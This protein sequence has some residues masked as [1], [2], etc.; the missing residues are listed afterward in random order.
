MTGTPR[1][2]SLI[3]CLFVIQSVSRHM[4]DTGLQGMEARLE[5]GMVDEVWYCGSWRRG[6]V[7]PGSVH[8]PIS[9]GLTPSSLNAVA[10]HDPSLRAG[11]VVLGAFSG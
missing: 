10:A 8:T 3:V 11:A 7:P 6:L 1:D 4:L 2:V 9:R 5:R